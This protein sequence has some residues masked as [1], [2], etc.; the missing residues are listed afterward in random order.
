M[1]QLISL[2]EAAALVSDGDTLALGGMTLYRRPTRFCAA[3]IKRA[4][5]N[6]T[7]VTLTA[8]YE[9]DL[10]VGAGVVSAVRTCYFGLQEFGLAPMFTL[11]S[12]RGE[13]H[14]IEETEMSLA[15]GLRASTAGIG[16]MPSRA[17]LGTDLPALRP[18]VKTVTDPYTG[19]NLTAFPAIHLDVAVIHAVEVDLRGNARLN[20]NLGI[21]QELI[22]VAKTVIV[23]AERRVEK[24]TKSA[25]GTIVPAA[26]INAIVMTPQGAA[27]SSCYPLYPI[28]GF[29]LMRYVEQ[30]S[31]G[32]FDAHIESILSAV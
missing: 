5:R 10:M 4:V 8:G 3:L 26:A 2:D 17:W 11:K 7:L 32:E 28:D 15:M 14:I 6:L 1:M 29:G 21:D 24:L 13:L 20:H 18:D 31:A 23:T 19:E 22:C 9:S 16:F 30:C 12:Q 27:P 25:D